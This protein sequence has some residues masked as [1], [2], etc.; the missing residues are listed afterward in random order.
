[1][2]KLSEKLHK[3]GFGGKQIECKKV[4]ITRNT[5]RYKRMF[6]LLLGALK[7]CRTNLL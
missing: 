1:M 5:L 2:K 3:I 4:L 7:K 6:G